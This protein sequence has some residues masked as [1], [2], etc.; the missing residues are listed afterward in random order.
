MHLYIRASAPAWYLPAVGIGK[1]G[2]GLRKEVNGSILT[3]DRKVKSYS[4]GILCNYWRSELLAIAE[5]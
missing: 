3:C 5:R 4:S 2:R 1:N